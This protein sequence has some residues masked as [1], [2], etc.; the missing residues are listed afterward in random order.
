MV[1]A[2][3]PFAR[4]QRI[5]LRDGRS[6]GYAEYGDPAGKPV[7]FFHG[8]P[9]SRLAWHTDA[10]LAAS[11]GIR[12]IAPE[13]PGYGLSDFQPGRT[14]LDWPDDVLELADALGFARFAVVG[15]SGGGLYAAACAYKI[16][17]RLT[18]AA[19]VSGG[20]PLNVPAAIAGMSRARRFSIALVTKAPWLVRQVA[21]WEA[22]Q[23]ARA[24]RRDA[25]RYLAQRAARAPA[26]DRAVLARPEIR[27]MFIENYAEAYRSGPRGHAWDIV[28]FMRPWGFRPEEITA[29]VYLWHGEKDETTPLSMGKYLASAIP[30]CRAYF[31]PEEGHLL[32][33]N[34][35]REILAA[36][37]C[38]PS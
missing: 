38:E 35:W 2:V 32:R 30:R 20:A 29:Q 25:E 36:L 34:H 18:A 33:F 37:V 5:R 22:W 21:H 4:D 23:T 10:S 11:L 24:V 17:H 26:P 12:L 14:L 13:R 27:A 31:L 7:F 19:I 8:V 1:A 15:A 6:L 16:P 9:G 3:S 28:L